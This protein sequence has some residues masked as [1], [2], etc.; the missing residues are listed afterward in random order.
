MALPSWLPSDNVNVTGMWTFTTGPALTTGAAM[1]GAVLTSP[2]ITSPVISGTTTI[3][4]GATFTNPTINA[5]VITG[6]VTIAS[7]AT[8]TTPTVRYTAQALTATGATGGAGTALS[9]VTPAV[10]TLTGASG[11]GIDIP[12]GAAI[13]GAT[14]QLRNINATGVINVY[15]VGGTIDG[16]TGTT[17][18]ALSPTGTKGAA[19]FCA[20]AGQ[21]QV[22]GITTT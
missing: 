19:L 21:W 15:A 22:S 4:T 16:V 18:F 20:T 12:T 11:A 17:A 5:A 6:T 3:A 2:T 13:A 10:A 1:T 14:Y 9:A 7:G 8:L